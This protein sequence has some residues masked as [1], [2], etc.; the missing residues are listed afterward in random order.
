[1]QV[2]SPAQEVSQSPDEG[3]EQPDESPGEEQKKVLAPRGPAQPTAAEISEHE[4]SGHAAHRSW[5]IHCVRARKAVQPHMQV[6]RASGDGL[7]TLHM[8]YFYLSSA[9]SGEEDVMPHLVVRCD[10]T[11]RT[12]RKSVV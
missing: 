9:D 8:D 12:D 5:C 1:M 10:K 4:A 6:E 3:L 7:P 11:R 2:V